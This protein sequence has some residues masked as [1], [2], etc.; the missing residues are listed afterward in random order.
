MSRHVLDS[1]SPLSPGTKDLALHFAVTSSVSFNLEQFPGSVLYD[2]D[3]FEATLR[4]DQ[5]SCRRL[6]LFSHLLPHFLGFV[7][8]QFARSAQQAWLALPE[9]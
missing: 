4:Q 3:I 1:F 5:L 6:L 7:A 9:I 8:F 2:V